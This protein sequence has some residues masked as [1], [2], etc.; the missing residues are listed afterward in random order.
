MV[1]RAFKW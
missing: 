1:I